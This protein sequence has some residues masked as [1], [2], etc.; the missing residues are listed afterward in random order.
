MALVADSEEIARS[1]LE[2]K[3]LTNALNRTCG[4]LGK[5]L[6]GNLTYQELSKFSETVV[7]GT[8]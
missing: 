8:F 7:G 5:D 2:D 1:R 6:P 4:V 3:R